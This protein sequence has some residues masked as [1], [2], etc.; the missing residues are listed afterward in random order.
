[1]ALSIAG[2]E[3]MWWERAFKACKFDPE[4]TPQLWCDNIATV[5]IATTPEERLTTKLKHVDTHQMWIKQEAENHRLSIAW[6][7]TAS[8]PADGLTKILSR[9]N[10]ERFIK[11][12]GLEDIKYLIVNV[13]DTTME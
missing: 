13:K 3:M 6:V 2:A 5:R 1:M 9:Q 11:Q 7:P 8:M 12:L 10:H 4:L